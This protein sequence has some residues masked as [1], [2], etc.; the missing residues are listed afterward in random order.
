MNARK[1]FLEKTGQ[2][3][4]LDFIS[5][6]YIKSGQLKDLVKKYNI[7]GLT[8]NP[9][10]FE[11][12]ISNSTIYDEDISKLK[13]KNLDNKSIYENLAIKDIK[14]AADILKDTYERTNGC[15]GFVSLEVSPLLAHDTKKT[16]EEALR[17]W[18]MVDRKNLM[19]K[20]PGTLE[21]MPAIRE[22][23]KQGLNINVTLLF[24]V[25]LY[26]KAAFSYLQGLKD[27][28]DMGLAIDHI[29]SVASFFVS[30]IDTKI[31]KLLDKSALLG[32]VAILNAYLAYNKSLSIYKSPKALELI[33]KKAN[34]QRVLWASTGT[35]NPEY[36]DCMYVENL[37]LPNTINTLPLKTIE[38]FF[39]HG[40]MLSPDVDDQDFINKLNH[41]GIDFNKATDE[42]LLEGIE[43]FKNGFLGIL[44]LLE[45][46]KSF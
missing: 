5:R 40:Q 3:I 9:S 17:L 1:A 20:V 14:D 27:R 42:L 28:T 6:D 4:W 13:N 37:V 41:L 32:K 10:I 46:K 43:L 18:Q 26:E 7:M 25:V 30:R 8:S 19:I 33:D 34:Q 11:K 36:S 15:D 38:A 16:I 45:S 23:I 22:L 2:S 35:K 21:G 12:A 31:D 44:K 29:H 39:D 24:S